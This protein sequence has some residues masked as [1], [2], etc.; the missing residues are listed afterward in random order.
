M[1]APRTTKSKGDTTYKWISLLE[2][3]GGNILSKWTKGLLASI[4]LQGTD[5][6]K[7]CYS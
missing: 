7:I 3:F 1:N 2:I 6:F 4:L 5:A